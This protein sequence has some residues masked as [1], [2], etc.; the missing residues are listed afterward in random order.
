MRTASPFNQSGQSSLK[1]YR[2]IAPDMWGKM[3]SRVNGVN[4]TGIYG[5][6]KAMGGWSSIKKP[7]HFTW[8]QYAEFLLSTLPEKTRAQYLK[9]LEK[10]KWHWRVQGAP[11]SKAFI[12]QLEKEGV[13]VKRSGRGSKSCKVNTDYEVIYLDEMIDDTDVEDFKKAPSWKR[14]CITIM[15]NDT[16]CKYMG[17]T[18]TKKDLARRAEIMEKYKGLEV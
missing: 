13:P 8:K 18:R 1:L 5:G 15:K 11:R 12:A 6:T 9:K 10:S 3:V 16:V 2:V 7:K 17:F 14:F 4:F